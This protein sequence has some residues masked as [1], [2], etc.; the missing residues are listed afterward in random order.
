MKLDR[1]FS[2]VYGALILWGIV[3]MI[4]CLLGEDVFVTFPPYLD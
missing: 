4:F 1:F 2:V 3:T